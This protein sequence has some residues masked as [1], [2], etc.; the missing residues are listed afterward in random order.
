MQDTTQSP[1]QVM[2]QR[3][4]L[5]GVGVL[6][7]IIVAV[8]TA[9]VLKNVIPKKMSPS[10]SVITVNANETVAMYSVPGAIVGLSENLYDQQVYDGSS[11][12]VIYKSPD[13][14]YAVSTLTPR[15]V[16][17][18][19]KNQ[20]AQ[21]DTRA[22]QDQTTTFMKT[23]SYKKVANS[24]DNGSSNPEYAT[25]V[26]EGAVCQLISSG[27]AS[28]EDVSVP[29]SHQLA[30]AEKNAINEEYAKTETLLNLYT[31]SKQLPSF[32]LVTRTLVSE[33]DKAFAI[34]KLKNKAKSPT[35]LF[36]S[37]QDKWSF[38][39]DL[40]GTEGESNGKYVIT[41]E[42]KTKLNDPKYNGFLTRYI[43]GTTS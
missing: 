14:S 29:V 10:S 12:P 8:G 7:L 31:G 4:M 38:V 34:L 2:K 26:S 1:R 6:V 13:R 17:F 11:V 33:G 39:A 42:I 16:L 19:G 5:L 27:T 22:I 18:Y 36:A 40:N 43:V 35:L 21:N 20:A 30:C 24:T 3:L 23:K 41:P 25:Y 9:L 37:V 15:N 32:N 28:P